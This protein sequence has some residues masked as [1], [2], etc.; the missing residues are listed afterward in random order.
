MHHGIGSSR[1]IFDGWLPTLMPTH[2]I[3]RFD[4]RGHGDSAVDGDMPLDMDRLSDD[5]LTVMDAA[6]V[7][8][9][10]LL[11][12]SIGATIALHTALHHP[13]R[14]S[15][16]TT[17]N[18]A[19]L[20]TSIQAVEN[21]RAMIEQDGME[22]WSL[23]M[24]EGR[25]APNAIPQDAWQWFHRQQAT[26]DP[27]T[28]LRLLAALVGADLLDALPGLR[29]PL[30][31]LHP[32]RSPFIPVPVVADLHQRVPNARL[33]VFGGARH[34]LPFSHAAACAALFRDFIL[35]HG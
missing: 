14:V 13:G 30:T 9:A 34:G 26:A 16:L 10:H 11:G 32:D 1:R 33:H 21:W 25:F 22:A 4:M 28:V 2:R 29:P 23:F 12:E 15:T 5:L 20:G 19:H 3:L 6:G 31:I 27:T 8:C 18:G 24:M 35:E 17:S 7:S